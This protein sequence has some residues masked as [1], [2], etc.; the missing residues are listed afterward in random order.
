MNIY[1]YGGVYAMAIFDPSGEN[2][3]TEIISLSGFLY[4]KT[5]LT[6][7][8]VEESKKFTIPFFNPTAKRPC[9]FI[10]KQLIGAYNFFLSSAFLFSQSHL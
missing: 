9:R 8:R 3:I 7:F 1:E 10:S 5:L 4:L 2:L 6:F